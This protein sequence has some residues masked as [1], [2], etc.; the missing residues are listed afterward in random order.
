[1]LIVADENIPLL[2]A[3]FAG[4]GEIR[5][6]PGRSIDRDCV[7]DADVLL[8][9]SV[10]KVDRALLEGSRVR[11][12]GTCTIGTDHLDLPYF[13]EA[14]IH[15]SSAP[16]CNARG[17][18]DYVLGS[19]LT[20][21]ELDGAD[22][23]SRTYGVVGA[24]EV[25]GRL[26]EVL[27]G[28]GWKVLVCDPPRQAAERGNYV[29]LEQILAECDV[30]SLHTPLTRSGEQ[31]TWH[32]LDAERLASLRQGA[33]LINASRGP[34]IDNIALRELLLDREDVLAVLDVWEEEPQVD[35][36]LADLCVIATPHIAGYSLDG[37]QRGTAQI[38]QAF[39][40]WRGET[41][42][43]WLADL[44]PRPW[45]A[46]LELQSDSD[47]VW[48]LATLCRAVYDPRRDDADFR[49]SLSADPAQQRANFDLLRKGYPVRREIEGL[50]VRIDGE[51]AALRQ[52]ALALGCVLEN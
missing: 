39:C 51:S 27:R 34:V 4:F 10:T 35:S 48:A 3:F 23:A 8:V 2:D 11:F 37:K 13:A 18:V 19:L 31:A 29:G 14:G 52:I 38:Y 5:R 41:A 26:V 43:V 7:R 36:E 16:G 21:A 1:M 30:I 9:R 47:P 46:R 50:R 49:R 45:L 24:G 32:L 25:G 40:A 17:V 28:L 6:Y 33:W 42:Q 22:L 44:L 15:W 12:V 20:L